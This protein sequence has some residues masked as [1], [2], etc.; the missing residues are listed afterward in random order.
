MK[1]KTTA[2]LLWFFLGVLGIHKFYLGKTGMGILYLLTGG[3]CGIGLL[4][5]LFTL[6]GQV[7]AYNALFMAQRAL[8]TGQAQQQTVVVNVGAPASQAPAPSVEAPA[9]A[10]APKEEP[11]APQPELPSDV[12]EK[13][14]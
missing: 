5:D 3:L 6:G 13:K 9:S 4:V 8:V 12:A 10:S 11:Q 14:H 2:Y 1:S 7:D